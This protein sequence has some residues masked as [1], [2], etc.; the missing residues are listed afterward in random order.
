MAPTRLVSLAYEPLGNVKL[1]LDLSAANDEILSDLLEF[2]FTPEDWNVKQSAELFSSP[3]LLIE[4][5]EQFTISMGVD[6]ENTTA[7]YA[8]ADPAPIDVKVLDQNPNDLRVETNATSIQLIDNVSEKVIQQAVL[9]SG[10]QIIAND[11]AIPR[12]C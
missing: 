10:L 11:L 5:D 9:A 12:N 6:I 4:G 1:I 3:D 2:T 8:D 7:L